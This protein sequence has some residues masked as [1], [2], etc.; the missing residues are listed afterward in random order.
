[1]IPSL[2]VATSA[3]IVGLLGTAHFI[4]T[5]RGPKLLPRDRTLKAAMEATTP[6]ITRQTTFWRA[7]IGFNASHSLGAVF[8]GLIYGYLALIHPDWLFASTFLQVVGVVTLV[9]YV[10]LA[11]LYWFITPLA[12]TSSALVCFVAGVAMMWVR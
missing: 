3:V 2:L 10:V 6:V 11:K 8:F 1:M 7:W 4:L 12:G 9:V 5:F